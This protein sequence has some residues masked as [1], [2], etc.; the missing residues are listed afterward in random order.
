MKGLKYVGNGDWLLGVPARDLTE[1]EVEVLG[2]TE[3]VASGLYE[4]YPKPPRKRKPTSD[5][6]AFPPSEDK[7]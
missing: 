7:E 4:E 6:S 5:K 1:Q 3:L 2:K